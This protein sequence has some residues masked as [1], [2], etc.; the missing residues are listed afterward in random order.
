MVNPN[1]LEKHVIEINSS[2]TPNAVY[3]IAKGFHAWEVN[4]FTENVYEDIPGN[5]LNVVRFVFQV[6]SNVN[7]VNDSGIHYLSASKFTS[8]YSSYIIKLFCRCY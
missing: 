3:T 6:S 5:V 8:K 2:R 4:N 1:Y 7:V